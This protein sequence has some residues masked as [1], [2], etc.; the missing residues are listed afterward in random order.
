MLPGRDTQTRFVSLKE[1]KAS[2]SKQPLTYS[3]SPSDI[4]MLDL[5]FKSVNDSYIND[6]NQSPSLRTISNIHETRQLNDPF[7][8][9]KNPI[10]KN[11]PYAPFD[12]K[13]TA[14]NMAG[15]A[16]TTP[17]EPCKFEQC[18]DPHCPYMHTI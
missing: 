5:L 2:P 11:M 6:S 7:T 4:T 12:D 9:M 10:G 13:R 16:L 3:F 15:Y 17:I 1:S 18:D 14:T 8:I